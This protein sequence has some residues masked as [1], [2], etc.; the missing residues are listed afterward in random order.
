MI[1]FPSTQ[2]T[3][4][5]IDSI[6]AAIGRVVT[7]TTIDSTTE[8]TAC[9][10]DPVTQTSTNSFCEVCG[11]IHFIPTY[12]DVIVSGHVTWNTADDIA[13]YAGGNVFE[14]DCRVQIKRSNKNLNIIDRTESVKVDGRTLKI[15]KIIPRGVPQLNRIILLLQEEDKDE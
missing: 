4:E 14:G 12:L 9:T 6:R 13:P 1:V 11:G 8:C 10:L 15:D 3:T 5:I 2:E 7:F